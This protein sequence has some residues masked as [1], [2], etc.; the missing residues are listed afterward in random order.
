MYSSLWGF[1][2]TNRIIT[3]ELQ[4][5]SDGGTK[6]IKEESSMKIQQYKNFIGGS[7]DCPAAGG[8]KRKRLKSTKG[9]GGLK[10]G[11]G[12][13]LGRAGTGVK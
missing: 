12:Q 4:K 10:V 5:K 13:R 8:K 7:R 3:A 9:V 2:G 6:V 11:G 1:V